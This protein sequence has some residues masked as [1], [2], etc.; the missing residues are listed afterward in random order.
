MSFFSVNYFTL[1]GVKETYYQEAEIIRENYLKLQQQLHPDRFVNASAQAKQLAVEYTAELNQ[2][3]QTLL[4][5]VL[6][7]I[8]LLKQ[9]GGEWNEESRVTLPTDF[10]E[11]QLLWQEQLEK[12]QSSGEEKI[13]EKKKE[14]IAALTECFDKVILSEEDY[15]TIR[16]CI[17]KMQ[18]YKNILCNIK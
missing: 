14:L 13:Y 18:F 10:L 11:E 8:Y 4:D 15:E 1:L 7:A 2:A 5:P 3:Y 6:R 16:H 9:K 12:G 17:Y